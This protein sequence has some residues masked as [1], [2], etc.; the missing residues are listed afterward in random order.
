MNQVFD[1]FL[2]CLLWV[3][4]AERFTVTLLVS[5]FWIVRGVLEE[6]LAMIGKPGFRRLCGVLAVT[7]GKKA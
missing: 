7:V 5:I 4:E 2:I 3:A 1:L 6:A